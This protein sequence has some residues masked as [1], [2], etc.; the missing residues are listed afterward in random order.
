MYI[1]GKVVILLLTRKT[2]DVSKSLFARHAF[3]RFRYSPGRWCR[4]NDRKFARVVN[5]VLFVTAVK[6]VLFL[7]INSLAGI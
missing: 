2:V 4:R 1:F 3:E 7:R 5:T 6:S